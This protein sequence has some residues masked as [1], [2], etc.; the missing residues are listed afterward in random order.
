MGIAAVG[1]LGFYDGLRIGRYSGEAF[2][3]Y[4]VES[5]RT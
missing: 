5:F 2:G 4:L 1:S 3:I